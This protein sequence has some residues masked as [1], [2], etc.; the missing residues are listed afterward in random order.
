LSTN[1]IMSLWQQR[2]ISSSVASRDLMMCRHTGAERADQ[3]VQWVAQ[4]SSALMWRDCASD[5]QHQ[6][7][8]GLSPAREHPAVTEWLAQFDAPEVALGDS[9]LATNR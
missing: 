1:V 5:I 4:A 8:Q 2:K 6:L 3:F 9:R 7:V